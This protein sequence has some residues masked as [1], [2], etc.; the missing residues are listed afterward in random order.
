MTSSTHIDHTALRED[1]L[2]R[3]EGIRGVLSDTALASEQ[4]RMLVPEAV[5]AL[6]EAGLMRMNVPQELGGWEAPPAT[7]MEVLAALAG[8]DTA[9]GWIAMVSNNSAGFM[10]AFLPDGGVDEV[11]AGNNV[12]ICSGVAAPSGTATAVDGGFRLTGYWRLCSGVHHSSWLR[13][14]A[15]IDGNPEKRVFAVVPQSAVQIHDTWH[16][17]GLRATGSSDVSLSDEF[18]PAHR[19]LFSEQRRRGGARYRLHGL[20]ASSHEHV[21]IALGLGRRALDELTT[22]VGAKSQARGVPARESVLIDIGRLTLALDSV[23]SLAQHSYARDLRLL[24]DEDVDAE[25]IGLGG[26]ALAAYATDIATECV[27]TA[28]RCAGTL[29]LYTPNVFERMLRDIH[30]ATQHVM[31]QDVNYA[32]LGA[33]RLAAAGVQA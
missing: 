32:Q 20:P 1:L 26:P 14:T 27:E 9:A 25:K 18:V 30:G 15:A 2:A 24:E 10:G 8:I 4:A 11:F 31:V 6:N 19:T 23:T 3:V 16:V 29:A 21:G 5:H 13:L 33:R 12:P 17:L 28:Y 22:A 7:Q